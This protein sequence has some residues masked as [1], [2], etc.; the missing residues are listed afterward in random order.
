[1][2]RG[3]TLRMLKTR[4]SAMI[5]AKQYCVRSVPALAWRRWPSLQARHPPRRRRKQFYKGRNVTIML[6][7]P[8]GGSYDMYARLA[9]NHM[10]KYIPGNPN[11]IVEHRPGGGGVR[12]VLYF[13]Q[14]G[15]ARRLRD[16]AVPG[17]HRA[18]PGPAARDRQVEDAGDDLC[19]L[20]LQRERDLRAPQGRAGQ[21]AGGDA[22]AF[23]R[24]S[25]AP[26]R[27]RRPIRLRRS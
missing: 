22:E 11:I 7:H 19:R 9:A 25:A 13:Y 10:K 14:S 12:A 24:M 17:D 8:P 23:R 4:R 27:P 18:H 6:G 2:R 5:G 26:A 20:V 3:T 21:D 15:A 16:G 1:M